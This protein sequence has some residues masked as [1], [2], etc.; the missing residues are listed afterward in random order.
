MR[1]RYFLILLTILVLVISSLACGLFGGSDEPSESF[2]TPA[3]QPTGEMA[4]SEEESTTE[5]EAPQAAPDVD[6]GDE[7][8]SE[9]GGYAFQ[10]IPGYEMEE[11]FGLASMAAA[12]AD[13]DLGPMFMLIGGTNDEANTEDQIFDKFMQ[14]A[15]GENVEILDRREI[16]VDSKPGILADINGEVDGQQVIGRIVVVAVTPNHQFTMFASAPEDRWTEVEDNFDAV[17]ASI[18]FFEPKEIDFMEEFNEDT[19]EGEDQEILPMVEGDTI[20]QWATFAFASSEYGSDDWSAQQATGEP[21]TF[22]CGDEATAWAASEADTVEWIEFVYD[23]SVIASEINIFQT[24]NPDQVVKVQVVDDDHHYITVYENDPEDHTGDT[25]PYVLNIPVEVEQ[26]V[27]SVKITIDQSQLQ[28]WNEIDA[29]ELVGTTLGDEIP[30]V[31]PVEDLS[32]MG[33]FPESY[34]D[35]PSG[36]FAYLLGSADGSLPIIVDQGTLQDQS[37]S[38][39]YVIGLISKDQ[40]NAVTLFIPLDVTTGVLIMELYD[41][42]AATKGPGAAVTKG[43]TLFTNK[44]GIIVIEAMKGTTIS[45]TFAFMAMDENGN[46]ISVTGF[47]NQLPLATP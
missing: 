35:L 23:K 2:S 29:V 34:A 24:Y 33:G 38:A 19:G 44:D 16:T 4:A 40:K 8:R 28:S 45:G 39:E 1:K 12:D 15:E 30:A 46:E 36:G 11:F 18:Y 20:H 10:P 7:Y 31:P 32:A 22:E 42:S 41:D 3:D 27:F 17:L 9:A 21:D 13:T 47:F 43:L 5:V 26:P 6:L 37:T 25:C 14:D